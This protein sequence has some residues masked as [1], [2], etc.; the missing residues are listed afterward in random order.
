MADTTPA[1][2]PLTPQEIA[3]SLANQ[4]Q[5]ERELRGQAEADLE[6]LRSE[7]KNTSSEEEAIKLARSKIEEMLPIALIT[8][9]S[10]MANSDSDSVRSSISKF[11]VSSVLDKKL[12]DKDN[13]E[14]KSLLTQLQAN[15]VTSE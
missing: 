6:A 4:L 11:V 1:G 10:L 14:L 9:E 12:E 13:T 7:F 3:A 2:R 5:T 8:M 15:Q